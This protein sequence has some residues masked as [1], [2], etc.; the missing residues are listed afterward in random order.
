VENAIISN[1]IGSV[2]L[3]TASAATTQGAVTTSLPAGR[4]TIAI[5]AS[6]VVVTNSNVDV[7][8]KI[9]AC[10]NQA[11]ADGTLLRVERVVPGAGSFTIFGTANA[12]AATVV[13]W[14]ILGPWGGLTPAL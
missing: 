7:N 11:A 10:I 8:S 14:A 4:V 1:N 13:D 6:S 9:W 5:G 2:V 12:T 3:T